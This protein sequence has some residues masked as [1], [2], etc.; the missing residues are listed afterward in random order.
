MST[1]PLVSV[2]VPV[3]NVF[4]YLKDSLDSVINQT[5]SRM[6]IVIVDDGSNDGSEKIC[7]EYK[8]KDTR[9]TVI[10]QRNGGLSA[11]RN[12]GL[13]VVHGDLIAFLDSDDAYLPNM[14][15]TMIRMMTD[16]DADIVVCEY[17]I[18]HTVERMNVEEHDNRLLLSNGEYN[19]Q[20]A[21]VCFFHG[22]INNSVWNKLY[23][24]HLFD[25]IRF[26]EGHVFEDKGL[27]P[28]L[29]EK[30]RKVTVISRPLILYR[31]RPD[32]ITVT[33]SE[34][35][36]ID[37]LDSE[38][39][40]KKYV[41]DHTPDVFD[42]NQRDSILSIQLQKVVFYYLNILYYYR[43]SGDVIKSRF[44][45]EIRDRYNEN[46]SYGLRIKIIRFMYRINKRLCFNCLR[47]NRVILRNTE[48]M[49]RL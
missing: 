5:Y 41:V 21:L 2:I 19:T 35:N 18:C 23:K 38:N 27:M 14:L 8:E 28:Y 1:E 46:A 45:G 43:A 12:T 47:A 3:Y 31:K 39:E 48:K 4:P 9:I 15:E 22:G 11:A 34:E 37:W 6:E 36:A 42:A 13:E 30:A 29:I 17:Y 44:E 40:M 20:D 25:G 16:T 33:P 7:D 10:H 26:N 49:R 24:R 32:S